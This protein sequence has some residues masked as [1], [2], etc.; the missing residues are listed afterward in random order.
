MVLGER[1]LATAIGVGDSEKMAP[2]ILLSI[3]FHGR[4]FILTLDS[5]ETLES[6]ESAAKEFPRNQPMNIKRVT[7]DL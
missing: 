4:V 3:G 7:S 5:C 2:R 1:S 6:T